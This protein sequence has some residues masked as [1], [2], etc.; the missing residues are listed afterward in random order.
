MN[1]PPIEDKQIS[2]EEQA[3]QQE[4]YYYYVIQE[5]Y[6]ICKVFGTNKVMADLATLKNH[7]EKKED[8]PRIVT[9]S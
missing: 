4:A 3:A 5:F 8:K 7:V 2:E 1:E 6:A 9:L